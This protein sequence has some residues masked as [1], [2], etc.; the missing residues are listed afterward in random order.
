MNPGFYTY[1]YTLGL[2]GG[3]PAHLGL[4]DFQ[5]QADP[6]AIYMIFNTPNPPIITTTPLANFI[7]S[8]TTLL[9]GLTWAILEI[10]L[11]I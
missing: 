11:Q 8:N 1:T 6:S 3:G 10:S 5:I 2:A 9:T 4:A 7:P